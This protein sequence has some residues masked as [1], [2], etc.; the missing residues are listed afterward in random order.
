[1]KLKKII[2][3]AAG[4]LVLQNSVHALDA[5][6]PL[7]T[8]SATGHSDVT[9]PQSIAI[10]NFTI[11]KTNSNVKLAQQEVRTMSDKLLK[12]LKSQSHISLQTSGI[13]VSPVMSYKD[14]T[15]KVTGYTAN[16]TIEVKSKIVD[17]GN[18]IDKA[19]ECGVN[20]VTAPQLIASDEERNKAKLEAIAQATVNAKS[21][22]DASLNAIGL[23]ATDVKQITVQSSTPNTY[24]P[25]V[26]FMRANSDSLATTS[27]EA[28]VDT[29]SADVNIVIGY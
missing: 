24:Q 13:S 1:M 5:S 12:T 27:V 8:I 20:N 25:K 7:K 10:M 6:T 22:A 18:I 29:I 15:P 9:V 28:G 23:K 26:S 21:Q 16:Y 3:I 2:K 4:L 19:V 17:S 14:S 11:S